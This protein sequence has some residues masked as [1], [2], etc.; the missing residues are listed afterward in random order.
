MNLKV[1]NALLD[2]MLGCFHLGLTET[3]G[4]TVLAFDG[5]S[6]IT[7]GYVSGNTYE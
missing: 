7:M 6:A 5:Q 3:N 2:F 4:L 1:T